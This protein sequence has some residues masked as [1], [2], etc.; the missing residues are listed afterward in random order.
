MQFNP[1]V[2]SQGFAT[3]FVQRSKVNL[4]VCRAV[5]YDVTEDG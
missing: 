4:D 3:S 2:D 1:Y 5:Y